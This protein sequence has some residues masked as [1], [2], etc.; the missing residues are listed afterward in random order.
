MMNRTL[1]YLKNIKFNPLVIK[2]IANQGKKKIA[3]IANKNHTKNY[4][5]YLVVRKYTTKTRPQS[6]NTQ[7]F[8]QPEPPNNSFWIIIAAAG[9][10]ILFKVQENSKT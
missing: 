8:N 3:I 10:G 5:Q 2:T 7:S 4:H 6:F 1:Q 9:C